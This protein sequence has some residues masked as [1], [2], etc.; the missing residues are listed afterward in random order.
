MHELKQQISILK[1]RESKVLEHNREL[2]HMMID[3]ERKVSDMRERANAASE[4][5]N[6][7]EGKAFCA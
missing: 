3:M 7:H 1:Q 2:Q 5:V 4:Q 6:I